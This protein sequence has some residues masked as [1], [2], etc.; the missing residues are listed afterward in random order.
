MK[1]EAARIP[2]RIEG[3]KGAD[4]VV[5]GPVE[6]DVA[7][8]GDERG[9]VDP[10]PAHR[11]MPARRAVRPVV[12]RRGSA[13]ASTLSPTMEEPGCSR[14][15]SGD[16]GD[17]DEG[18]RDA[19]MMLQLFDG[20]GETPDDVEVGGFGGQHGGQRGVGGFAIESGAADAGAGKEVRDGLHSSLE[21][22]VAG[23]RG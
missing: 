5:V 14:D 22:I 10:E 3:K 9:E 2:A 6:Q 12:E 1:T 19:A 20:P 16:E 11:L 4:A 13:K 7:E 8:S 21:S 18:M 17:C 23:W 15:R